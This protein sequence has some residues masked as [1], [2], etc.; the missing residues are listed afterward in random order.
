MSTTAMKRVLFT[1]IAF[2]TLIGCYAQ[3]NPKP[4]Y[5]VTTKGDTIRGT[6]D[7]RS[8]WQN[9]TVCRFQKDGEA[10]YHEYKPEDLKSYRID[11]GGAYY[12]SLSLPM[13]GKYQQLFALYILEGGVDLY[14]VR[15][16]WDYYYAVDD[17]GKV[18]E[19]CNYEKA[20]VDAEQAL[21]LNRKNIAEAGRIFNKD[22]DIVHKIW[23]GKRDTRTMTKLVR[24]YNEK[25][26]REAG[27]CIVYQNNE[28][29][30]KTV[31]NK[32]FIE[33]GGGSL[34]AKYKYT[35]YDFDLPSVTLKGPSFYLSVCNDMTFERVSK[36]FDMQAALNLNF[37]TISKDGMRA[38]NLFPMIQVGPKYRIPTGGKCTPFIKAGINLL[39]PISIGEEKNLGGYDMDASEGLIISFYGGLGLDFH[40]SKRD[41]RISANFHSFSSKS[42]FLTLGFGISL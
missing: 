42:F 7:Y 39:V 37:S 12:V 6:I 3:V 10:V 13:E 9:A 18:A 15:K 40:S 17:E 19:I 32:W 25:Y 38:T 23:N 41:Y 24:E 35:F 20:S 8:D 27:E 5:I 31:K 36:Q 2:F 34:S 11:N 30:T 4:G 14:F 1:L 26:C 22:F 33:A 29:K 16:G 21:E 28:E